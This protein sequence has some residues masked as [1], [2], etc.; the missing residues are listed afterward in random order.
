MMERNSGLAC[1]HNGVKMRKYIFKYMVA[2]TDNWEAG[3]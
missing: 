2:F 3:T 1:G